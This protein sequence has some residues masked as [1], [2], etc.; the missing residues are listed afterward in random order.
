MENHVYFVAQLMCFSILIK[1]WL[2]KSKLTQSKLYLGYVCGM[3]LCEIL[4]K[5]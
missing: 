3:I 1:H 4:K 2:W 5:S